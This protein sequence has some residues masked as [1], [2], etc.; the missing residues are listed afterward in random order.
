MELNFED[1]PEYVRMLIYHYIEESVLLGEDKATE[2]IN[3]QIDKI[4][5]ERRRKELEALAEVTAKRHT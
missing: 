1:L 5:Y 3:S 2:I 4:G